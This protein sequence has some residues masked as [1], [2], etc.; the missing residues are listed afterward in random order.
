MIIVLAIGF[1]LLNRTSYNDEDTLGKTSSN[2]LNGGLLCEV[3]DKIYVA[4]PCYQNT[5]C[6]RSSDLQNRK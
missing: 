5:L 6:S 3:D 4:N 2:L 1:R